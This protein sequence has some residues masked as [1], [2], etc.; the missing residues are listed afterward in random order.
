MQEEKMESTL[1]LVALQLKVTY[2][3][4]IMQTNVQNN[5]LYVLTVVSVV[6]TKSVRVT[7]LHPED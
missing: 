2:Y 4:F 3:A 5:F 6:Y 7:V 1:Y